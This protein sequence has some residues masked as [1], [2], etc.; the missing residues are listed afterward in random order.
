MSYLLYVIEF[1]N[2]KRYFGI[3]G[4]T[5]EVRWRDHLSDAKR[6]KRPICAAIAKYNEAR[7]RT[8][9][10]GSMDY[11][12][13]LEIK[14]IAAFRTTDRR[15]GYNVGLGG[16]FN[17][18]LGNRHGAE[19]LVK[20]ADASRALVRTPASNA[21]RSAAL[22]GKPISPERR[23]RISA[24]TKSAMEHPSV[25]LKI[26]TAKSGFKFS[27]EALAARPKRVLSAETR[28]KIGIAGRGLKRSPETCERIRQA[29]LA[30]WAR[31]KS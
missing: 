19:A 13:E 3:T 12:H 4:R 2:G 29:K 21:K 5:A 28:A 8:L 20:I 15:F 7:M 26:S 10:I 14:A 9:V 1:P 17:P 16:D 30:T 18:M 27:P 31:K 24:A 22:R 23:S 11:I 6:L 25:R